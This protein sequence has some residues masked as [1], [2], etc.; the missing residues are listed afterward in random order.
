[1]AFSTEIEK[2]TQQYI[3]PRKSYTLK[4]KLLVTPL[5]KQMSYFM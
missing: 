1:M 4:E 3:Y 5:F 2:K